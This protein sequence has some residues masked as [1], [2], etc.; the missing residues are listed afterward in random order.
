MKKHYKIV[1]PLRFF[2]F[3]MLSVTIL[4][5]ACLTI[6]NIDQAQA[7]SV[8]RYKQIEIQEADTLWNIAEN[9]C[10]PDKDI[11]TYIDDI[12]EINDIS[13]NDVSPGDIVFVPIY[14]M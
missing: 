14:D 12:C 10:S 9:Y 11:R 13:A 4:T 7:A 1:N 8:N 2:A 3:V 5:M 6:F